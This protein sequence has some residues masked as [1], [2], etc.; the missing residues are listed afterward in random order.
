MKNSP[1]TVLWRRRIVWIVLLAGPILFSRTTSL[2]SGEKAEG[3]KKAGRKFGVGCKVANFVLSDVSRRQVE[4]ADFRNARWVVLFTLGTDCQISNRYL[5]DMNKLQQDF[6]ANG[7]QVLGID[8]NAGVTKSEM[9]EHVAEF[10]IGFPV[11]LDADQRVADM[12]NVQRTAEVFVLDG[13]RIVRYRGRIDDRFRDKLKQR[14]PTRNDLLEALQELWTGRKVSVA[15]T[16]PPGRSIK[17]L[18]GRPS[19][20]LPPVNAPKPRAGR[21][22]PIKNPVAYAAKSVKRGRNL[23]LS[24]C[25]DCHSFDGTGRDSDVTANAP[26]LTDVSTW[27][28]DGGAAETFLAIRDGVGDEMPAFREDFTDDRQIWDIVNFIRSLQQK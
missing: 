12:L 22:E 2:S 10:G 16:E 1:I 15:T 17:R 7:V 21:D 27:N 20:S 8:S 5:T 28:S 23:Y 24:S 6:A 4:L 19:D 14:A 25:V 13:E 11:L 9:V 26:D 18:N 3:I